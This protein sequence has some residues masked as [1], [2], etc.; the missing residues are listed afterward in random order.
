MPP[1]RRLIVAITAFLALCLLAYATL[2]LMNARRFQLFGE[3]VYRVDTSQKVV[4]LTLDDGPTEQT[5]RVLAALDEAGIRATF[6][7]NGAAI[8][9]NPDAAAKL[10]AAGH[11]LGNH[12]YSH[13]RLVLK[14]PAFIR[15]EIAATDA[16]I[17]AAG[18]AGDIHFRPPNGKKLV[19]L[20]F[21]L[22]QRGTKTI[23]WSIEPDSYGEIAGS[24][25]RIVAHV[26]DNVTPGA[27]ILLH[28]MVDNEERASLEAIRGIVETLHAQGY[29][30][31]T[32]SELLAYAD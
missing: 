27:I 19:Y 4:A 32:V 26:A 1:R 29:T 21:H 16:L 31:T 14:S 30:F 20:P 9:A 22:M 17:R 24:A 8:D 10:V 15:A 5:D 25:D 23:M 11:E 28:G 6:F 3:L 7:V 18:Q 12:G 13:T 2:A